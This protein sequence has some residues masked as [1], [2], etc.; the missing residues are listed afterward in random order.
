M[1]E[2]PIKRPADADTESPAYEAPAVEDLGTDDPVATAGGAVSQATSDRALKHEFAEVDV[3]A[4]LARVVELPLS[5]WSYRA[6]D[7]RVRHIGPMAQDFAAAFGVGEDDRHIHV[8]DSSGVALAAIQAL[9]ARLAEAEARI[10]G[11]QAELE[12]RAEPAPV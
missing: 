8:V 9:A 10:A 6:D 1:S 2:K 11:L 5:T 7:A 4:V 3:D 12:Q